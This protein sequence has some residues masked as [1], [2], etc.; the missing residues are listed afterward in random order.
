MAKRAFVIGEI[1]SVSSNNNP[2]GRIWEGEVI[3]YLSPDWYEVVELG[4]N[5]FYAVNAR[6][7]L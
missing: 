7:M 3:G 6:D 1:V 5:F 4:H 2:E